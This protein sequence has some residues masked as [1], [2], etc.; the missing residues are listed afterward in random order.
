MA[1]V[2]IILFVGRLIKEKGIYE[3][4]S[5]FASVFRESPCH[6][7][8]VGDGPEAG[9]VRQKITELGIQG[10]TTLAGYLTGRDLTGA[11]RTACVFTLPSYSEG[12]PTVVSEAMA[13]G[14]PV[15]TT[16]I[17]GVADHLV[18]GVNVLFVAPRDAAALARAFR[19]LLQDAGLRARMGAAN[20]DKVREFAPLNVVTDYV[21]AINDVLSKSRSHR[22]SPVRPTN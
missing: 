14:L 7:M 9:R 10:R 19:A 1:N 6:L 2:P 3:L 18:E 5:A 15:V 12:F 4:L 16:R 20:V 21:A 11:Y 22:R 17:R 13:A 8:L